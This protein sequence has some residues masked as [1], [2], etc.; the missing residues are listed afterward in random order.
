VIVHL[1][2]KKECEMRRW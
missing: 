2:R 1:K